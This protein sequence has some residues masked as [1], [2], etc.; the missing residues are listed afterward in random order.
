MRLIDADALQREI[1]ERWFGEPRRIIPVS[2]LIDE[3]PTVEPKRGTWIEIIPGAAYA[4]S[5]CGCIRSH[6]A[7][8]CEKCGA[9]NGGETNA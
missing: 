2:Q 9:M 6:A 3:Q 5:R 4:C 8:Y 7:N 1:A